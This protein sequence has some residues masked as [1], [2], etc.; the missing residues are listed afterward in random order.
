[1]ISDETVF[2]GPNPAN[3]DARNASNC[4]K[5]EAFVISTWAWQDFGARLNVWFRMQAS[6]QLTL[7]YKIF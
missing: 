6:S 5:K 7:G 1:V 4:K 2:I 3:N